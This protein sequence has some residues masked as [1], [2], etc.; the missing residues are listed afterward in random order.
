MPPVQAAALLIIPSLVTN[1]W[2][3]VAGPSF[4][5][6]MRRLAAMMVFVCLGTALGIRFLVASDT[7]WPALALGS[8]LAV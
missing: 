1:L 4:G 5:R 6:V 7:R 3:L 2:Q 8:V